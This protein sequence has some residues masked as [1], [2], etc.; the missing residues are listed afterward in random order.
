MPNV[1]PEKAQKSLEDFAERLHQWY[2]HGPFMLHPAKLKFAEGLL[3]GLSRKEAM[4]QVKPH[5]TEPTLLREAHRYFHDPDV[6]VY[7]YHR[8]EELKAKE[9]A[10]TGL[11]DDMSDE[12]WRARVASR[13][14]F[15]KLAGLYASGKSAPPAPQNSSQSPADPPDYWTNR[16]IAEKGRVPGGEK[17]LEEY[18]S[19]FDVEAES[20]AVDVFSTEL[21]EEEKI[22]AS[23]PKK[24]E[25]QDD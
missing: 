13:D 12:N 2:R 7:L 14:Q 19:Q 15:F 20:V 3:E 22:A 24:G 8:F 17:E 11:V 4:R 6:Q 25:D 9:I 23:A 1:L 18:K 5:C 21:S 10:I 16:F